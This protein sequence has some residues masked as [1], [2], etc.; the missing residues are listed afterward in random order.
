M[1]TQA[2]KTSSPLQFSAPSVIENPNSLQPAAHTTYPDRISAKSPLSKRWLLALGA[3]AAML[4]GLAN[5]GASQF[6]P[7]ESLAPVVVSGKAGLKKGSSGNY[8][9]WRRQR[10]DVRIDSSVEKIGANASEA[11]QAAFAAWNSAGIT[12]PETTFRKTSKAKLSSTPDGVSTILYAPIDIPGHTNDLAITIA[13]SDPDSGEIVEADVVINSKHD[14]AILEDSSGVG[15]S[16]T[17]PASDVSHTRVEATS[18]NCI[19]HSDGT[20]CGRKYDLQNV[21][22]HEAGHFLGLAEDVE[23]T[24]ATMYQCIS[25]CETQKRLIDADDQ[26]AVTELYADGFVAETQPE[27]A[28]CSGAHVTPTTH[29]GA[30]GVL[31][32]VLALLGV[33]SLRRKR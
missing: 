6:G 11:I 27:A 10:I 31:A 7:S 17:E 24:H 1:S 23:D 13:F 29:T 8:Q 32:S 5:V 20:Q 14:F 3:L 2:K 15:E 9:R 28:G 22:T 4:G 21:M 16:E 18:G 12:L 26:L 25:T 33:A 19:T 30:G